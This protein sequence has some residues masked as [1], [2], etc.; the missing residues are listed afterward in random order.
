MKGYLNNEK[1]T[2]D[3][4]TKDGWLHTGDIGELYDICIYVCV[5]A[6]VHVCVYVCM[7]AVNTNHFMLLN[8]YFNIQ[9]KVF[10]N[11]NLGMCIHII[12]AEK[13]TKRWSNWDWNKYQ[14]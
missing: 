13:S 7:C 3:T 5:R 4:I 14:I 10:I 2:A 12:Q 1:A 11:K 8:K 9:R 6:C